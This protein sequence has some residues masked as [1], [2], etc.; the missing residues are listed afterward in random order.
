MIQD[1]AKRKGG[2]NYSIFL[3]RVTCLLKT[4]WK[5]GAISLSTLEEAI[6]MQSLDRCLTSSKERKKTCI[7]EVY[8]VYAVEKDS[9]ESLIYGEVLWGKVS[10]SEQDEVSVSL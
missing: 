5:E 3:G 4:N 8:C 9:G 6:C 1:S 10:R 2:Y 7:S